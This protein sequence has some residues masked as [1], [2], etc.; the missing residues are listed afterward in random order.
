MESTPHPCRSVHYRISWLG[1]RCQLS[2]IRCE[3]RPYCQRRNSVRCH[4]VPPCFQRASTVC[5]FRSDG[6]ISSHS[7]SHSLTDGPWT[8]RAR[9]QVLSRSSSNGWLHRTE[10]NTLPSPLLAPESSAWIPHM[11]TDDQCF[12]TRRVGPIAR[13]L[14]VLLCGTACAYG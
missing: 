2:L 5:V 6:L 1:T 11:H 10:Y 8:S 4:P 12:E 9:L 7:S 13:A 3:G 14:T